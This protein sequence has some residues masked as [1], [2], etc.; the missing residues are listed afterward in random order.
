MMPIPDADIVSDGED[1]QVINLDPGGCCKGGQGKAGAGLGRS[2]Y[3][4][5]GDHVEEIRVCQLEC[6][7]GQGK[8]QGLGKGMGNPQV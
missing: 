6:Q 8:V 4:E 1:K 2:K 3:A 7:G 5:Q